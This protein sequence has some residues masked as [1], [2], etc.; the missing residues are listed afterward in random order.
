MSRVTTSEKPIRTDADYVLYWMIASRRTSF[1]F[2]LDRALAHCRRLTVRGDVRFGEGVVGR[3]DVTLT[4]DGPEPRVIA[5]GT[6][7]D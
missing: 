7:L 5:D 4:H 1:N 3:G 6:V 2:A